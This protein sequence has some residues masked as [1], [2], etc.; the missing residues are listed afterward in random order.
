MKTKTI[1]AVSVLL[2]SCAA[3]AAD[4]PFEKGKT[5]Y[6]FTS[7][8]PGAFGYTSEIKDIKGKWLLI[9]SVEAC[10]ESVKSKECWVN[11]DAIIFASQEK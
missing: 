11:S 4:S 10:E 5:Y 9:N 3:V 7:I 6:L 1:V 8:G 2:A